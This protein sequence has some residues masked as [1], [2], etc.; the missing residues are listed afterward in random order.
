MGPDRLEWDQ[1][2]AIEVAEFDDAHKEMIDLYNRIAWACG[3][4]TSVSNVR[5]RMRSF[6]IYARWHFAEEEEWMRQVH[7]PVYLDHKADHDRLLQDAGDFVNSF[8]VVLTEEDGGAI[9][10][11]FNYWLMRHLENKDL[12]LRDF[13][14]GDNIAP[15]AQ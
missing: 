12:K 15:A 6:M 1:R 7:Y 8:G 9:V 14:T 11:Y 4:G 3:N 13:V 2:L 10:R 5:E